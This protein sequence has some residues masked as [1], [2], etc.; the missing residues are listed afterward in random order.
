[1]QEGNE[2]SLFE[3]EDVGEGDQFMA[4]KPWKGAVKASVPDAYKPHKGEDDPPDATLELE[5]VYGYRC[6]DVRDN[7]RYDSQGM[8]L[9]HT[10][11]LGISLNPLENT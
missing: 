11:A 7:L 9:Y 8:V 5:Y 3:F 10:A 6:H 4:V 1:M 2:N